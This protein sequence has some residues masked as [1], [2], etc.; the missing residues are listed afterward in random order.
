MT[1]TADMTG[2]TV[3]VTGAN[4]GIGK[5]TATELARAGARVV[6]GARSEQRGQEAV[7]EIKRGAGSDE[8]ELLLMDL[9][10]LASVRSAAAEARERFDRLD[11]LVNNAGLTSS[12]REITGD[13][14]ELMFQVNH[15]G[16]FLLTELLLPLLK[17]TPSARIVNVASLAHKQGGEL[18][19]ENLQGEKGPWVGL[20]QYARTKLMNILWTIELARRLSGSGVT[21]NCLHPG[22]V[23]T[24]WGLAGDAKG[25]LR[26]GLWIAR[27]FFLSPERGARTSVYLASSPDV[28]GVSGKY[29]VKRRV[30]QPKR[31]ARDRVAARHLWD[32]TEHLLGL[33]DTTPAADTA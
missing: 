8:V 11:V 23:R 17:D 33:A 21:A 15:V 30:R 19:L 32:H 1:K 24:G 28:A 5:A 22:T 13:G 3:L 10:D 27:W 18:D 4:S 20:K 2:K 9:A 14:F 16:P 26:I 7:E 12:S 31:N 29:F 6:V 25:L